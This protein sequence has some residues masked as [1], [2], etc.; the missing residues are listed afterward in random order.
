MH[1]NKSKKYHWCQDSS[2]IFTKN[3]EYPQGKIYHAVE[4]DDEL[5]EFKQ[6]QEN[7]VWEPDI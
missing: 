5:P 7:G 2:L 4:A 6:Q 3:W 1:W